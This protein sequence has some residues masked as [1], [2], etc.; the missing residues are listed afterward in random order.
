MISVTYVALALKRHCYLYNSFMLSRWLR[1]T[2]G[3][4]NAHEN[5]RCFYSDTA[6]AEP[7]CVGDNDGPSARSSVR[8]ATVELTH[9][10]QN[11]NE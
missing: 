4:L 9:S 3:R 8:C 10:Q 1:H 5:A 7:L 11:V 2:H 6:S